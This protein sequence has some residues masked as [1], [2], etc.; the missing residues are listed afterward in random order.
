MNSILDLLR[1]PST[2]NTDIDGTRRLEV[3]AA[4]LARKRMLREVFAEFHHDFHRLDKQLFSATGA[5]IELGAGISPMKNS[6][7]DVLAT[8]IV[9][10]P[11][12]D[13][14]LDAEKM[15][16]PDSSVRVFYAQNSFHHFPHPDRFF[17]EVDRVV[18]PGGGVVL[19]EPYFGP[20]AS[21]L[22]RRLFRTETFNKDAASWDAE[23][24]GPMTGA[25]QALSYVVLFRDRE[26]FEKMHPTL[27]IVRHEL[28]SNY[29]K[30]LLS[31]GLNFRQLL[32]DSMSPIIG[33]LQWLISPANPWLALHHV[34]VLRKNAA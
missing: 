25:N 32:P 31:G 12:V 22:F 2:D 11:N 34:V 9:P 1:D 18:A 24:S 7:P 30:Y 5:R 21:F 20:A 14:V 13:K 19:L 26:T 17:D 6:Y 29:L 27:K 28:C 15:D 23:M 10:G 16:L 8:D 4:I 3:H 33:L